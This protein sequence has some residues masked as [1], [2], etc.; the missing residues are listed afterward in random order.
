[1]KDELNTITQD[2]MNVLDEDPKQTASETKKKVLA[3]NPENL[4]KLN[5]VTDSNEAKKQAFKKKK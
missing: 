5:E 4:K 3:L 2:V 1:M